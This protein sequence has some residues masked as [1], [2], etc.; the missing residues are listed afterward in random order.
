[1]C[2]PSCKEPD[3][4]IEAGEGRR[5][6]FRQEKQVVAVMSS[7]DGEDIETCIRTNE[8]LITED[9][10]GES[11]SDIQAG[12]QDHHKQSPS[13][14]L[15]LSGKTVVF[16]SQEW[17]A[18]VE[19][20]WE[21]EGEDLNSSDSS[22]SN[23]S[24]VSSSLFRRDEFM[25]KPLRNRRRSST[26]SS[27]SDSSRLSSSGCEEEL[28]S[29][30]DKEEMLRRVQISTKVQETLKEELDHERKALQK[31]EEKYE[32]LD[33][34]YKSVCHVLEMSRQQVRNLESHLV[35]LE[36]K[37]SEDLALLEKDRRTIG[38]ERE[39]IKIENEN[40]MHEKLSLD[41]E[42]TTFHQER[43][44]I[45]QEKEHLIEET[46]RLTKEQNSLLMKRVLMTDKNIMTEQIMDDTKKDINKKE[47]ELE[48]DL[49]EKN[50]NSSKQ[51]S[52]E[53]S[54]DNSKTKSLKKRQVSIQLNV[55][56]YYF[57]IVFAV[58]YE[59]A[60]FFSPPRCLGLSV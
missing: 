5:K 40:L 21:G 33:G 49:P 3:P 18:T 12:E 2:V 46:K 16:P 36:E 60:N 10:L 31:M 28:S 37:M 13:T 34:K 54:S 32:E 30:E 50:N 25:R 59:L 45:L 48:K 9:C 19:D 23:I 43:D 57:G 17:L 26:L 11:W 20:T 15:V 6:I 4:E 27:L 58:V 38:V 8:V 39:K 29:K 55:E 44:K 56:S 35:F 7:T 14:A 24:S 22:S 53:V 51:N 41:R 42:K 47:K 52:K 1:M